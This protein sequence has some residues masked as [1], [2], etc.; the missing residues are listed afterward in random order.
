MKIHKESQQKINLRIWQNTLVLS[1]SKFTNGTGI[2]KRRMNS[3]KKKLKKTTLRSI[4]QC[5]FQERS[6]KHST[7][8]NSEDTLRLGSQMAWKKW[9]INRTIKK[10]LLLKK[11][12]EKL[13]ETMVWTI[14]Q[15]VLDLILMHLLF[16]W[17]PMMTI[18]ISNQFQS[19]KFI[20]R[21][22]KKIFPQLK[23]HQ[24]QWDLMKSEK[25]FF[26]KK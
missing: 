10:I 22:L 13:L 12:K 9:E 19:N 3:S 20:E 21:I 23:L 14:L 18:P 4:R 6:W 25:E 11:T 2:L 8:M 17:L 26:I 24:D 15:R 16:N 1:Y 7:L 5:V